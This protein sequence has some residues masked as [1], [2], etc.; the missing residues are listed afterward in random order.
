M[1]KLTMRLVFLGLL[2]SF[3]TI[4]YAQEDDT[5][6]DDVQ[7]KGMSDFVSKI[8]YSDVNQEFGTL[9]SDAEPLYQV[10]TR[11]E[12]DRAIGDSAGRSFP[13]LM[14]KTAT[15]TTS[16]EAETFSGYY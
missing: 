8:R 3:T 2:L 15:N 6:P 9:L 5:V 7:W 11:F 13:F 12:W 16:T 1:V 14:C 10:A 4:A